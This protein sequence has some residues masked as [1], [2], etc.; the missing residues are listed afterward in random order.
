MYI[1]STHIIT[2]ITNIH[3][4]YSGE[5]NGFKYCAVNTPS[6]SQSLALKSTE[7]GLRCARICS[8]TND[9]V[10]FK[11]SEDDFLC[12]MLSYLEVCQDYVAENNNTHILA[13]RT[14]CRPGWVNGGQSCYKVFQGYNYTWSEAK[15]FCFANGSWLVDIDTKDENYFIWQNVTLHVP[16][17]IYLGGR[18]ESTSGQWLWVDMDYDLSNDKAVQELRWNPNEPS[19]TGTVE[20][21]MVLEI[22]GGWNNI[23]C[24]KR[25]P[26][27]CEYTLI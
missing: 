9:C 1:Q 10:A 11:Y 5:N 23:P 7:N 24:F 26:F 18:R 25:W 8:W 6:S 27:V 4:T 15:D 3:L 13:M 20:D 17:N 19:D 14:T 16:S 12:D 22:N 2:F 21:C